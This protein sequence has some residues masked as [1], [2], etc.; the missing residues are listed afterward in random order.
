[1]KSI[2]LFFGSFNPI[3]LGHYYLAEY[4][5][6]FS[7]VDQIWFVVSPRNPLKAESQLIDEHHRLKMIQLAT[8][9]IEYLQP[10]DVE[11]DMPKPSYTIDTLRRLTHLYPEDDFILLI[12]SDNMAIFDQWKDYQT[13]MDDFSVVVYPR[14]SYPY[15]DFEEKYPDMQVLEEAPFFD[16]SSTEIRE[17]I[18]RGED[19]IKWLH[20]EVARYIQEQGLYL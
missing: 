16:I 6:Q 3:H 12:G 18:K 1:M 20:P 11:F 4:I 10:C 14:E 13:I 17:K 19:T 15:Q 8:E 7:G 5:F 9:D 2:G